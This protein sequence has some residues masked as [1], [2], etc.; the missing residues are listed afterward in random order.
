MFV[1]DSFKSPVPRRVDPVPKS[2]LKLP[3]ADWVDGA[4]RSFPEA[5]WMIRC[6]KY[7]I[8]PLLGAATARSSS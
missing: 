3:G 7:A 2:V 8:A 6:H 1:S 4:R 5:D